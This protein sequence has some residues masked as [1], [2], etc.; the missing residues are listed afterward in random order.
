MQNKK[1]T[2]VTVAPVSEKAPRMKKSAVILRLLTYLWKHPF[3]LALAALLTVA[4]NV[5]ALWGPALAEE[6]VDAIK[7]R[8]NVDFDTV[9]QKGLAMLLCY[10]V[11]AGL[12]FI[13]SAVMIHLSKKVV[14]Q[15]RKEV[16]EHLVDLP[17]GYFDRNQTGDLISRLTYDIDTINAS[18]S[19]DLIQICAGV[20]TV[21]GAAIQMAR[22]KPILML[23]FAVTVPCLVFFTIYRTKKVKPLFRRRSAKLGELN[24]YTEEMLSGQKTIRAYGKEAIMIARF[25]RHNDEAVQ[26]HYEADYQGSVVGPSVNFINNVSLALI[27]TF[28]VLLCLGGKLSLGGL[29]AFNLYSRRFAGPINETANIISEIQ[30]AT[31]AAERVFRLLDERAEEKVKQGD[32]P[33]PSP[34]GNVELDGVN[35]RYVPDR[36]ILHDVNLTVK[37][38]ET[39]AIVGPTGGGK[40]TLISL[41]MRFYDPQTGEIRIDGQ[42]TYTTQMEDVRRAYAMVLQDTWL[43]GGTIAENLC[44]GNPDATREEMEAAARAAR[45]DDYIRS[46][47][48]GYETVLDENGVNLSKGQKQLLTIARAMLVDSPMLILD[49]AT[50]NVDSRT[51]QKLQEAMDELTKNKTCFIVAHRLSTVQN[52][53]R[54]IVVRDGRIVETGNH[55]TLLAQGGFYATLYNSQFEGAPQ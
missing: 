17:V 47:P 16:F 14:Y 36:P 31:S 40:T 26:A 28:G 46:L 32:L 55:A 35:F 52:A 19:N 49:E 13:L 33:L 54:I 29:T 20:I 45:I 12:T 4:A 41:L 9:Y 18:L 30:S 6:A 25:D 48:R 7:G 50:S 39:I 42:N 38:G 24:G 15:M 43:F 8:G 11:S 27:S 3:W 37:K 2:P 34:D 5:I 51:E 44:Y 53:S 1:N 10:A 22:I 21:V 23:V